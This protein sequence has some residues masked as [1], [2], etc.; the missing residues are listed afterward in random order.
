MV[1][2]AGAAPAPTSFV[3]GQ[4][5]AAHHTS[6]TSLRWA[7]SPEPLALL[8]VAPQVEGGLPGLPRFALGLVSLA[9]RAHGLLVVALDGLEGVVGDAVPDQ[10]RRRPEEA[11][12]DLYVSVEEG[13]RLPRRESF[14]QEIEAA[15]LR[16]HRVH[17]HPV[18]AASDHSPKRLPVRLRRGFVVPG[19]DGGEAT[20]DAVGSPDQ[21][22]PAPDRRVADLE[23][24]DG[25]LGIRLPR[26][27]FQ[28]RVERGVEEARNERVRRVVAPGRLPLV[29]RDDFEG[30]RPGVRVEDGG[31][32]QQRLVDAPEFLRP[33]VPVV[34][35]CEARALI[36]I[37]ESA[38]G[39][40]EVAVGDVGACEIRRGP[41]VEEET[42]EGG[43]PER[44]AS[45]V[46]P[47]H[48]HDEGELAVQVG[49]AAP[50]ALPGVVA[51]LAR[52]IK[53]GVAVPRLPVRVWG[54]E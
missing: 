54:E 45:V 10:A 39:V 16:A 18:E 36:H 32:L 9:V 7:I 19:S 44:R 46:L 4:T 1:I 25:P 8:V 3:F 24:E 28:H 11:V 30:E 5:N 22:M 27:L 20:G 52:R 12:A 23:I 17:V 40:E 37:G 14:Q 15:K 26:R 6:A 49:V 50:D 41:L 42:A 34:N 31:K 13:E 35:G 51:E 43:Q 38:D 53:A 48:P 2:G 47:E 21:K 29:P 33:E